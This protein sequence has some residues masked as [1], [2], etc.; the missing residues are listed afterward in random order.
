[1]DKWAALAHPLPTLGALAPTSPPLLQQRFMEKATSPAPAGSRVTPSSQEIRL[2]N[3]PTNS[4]GDPTR[5]C[6]KQQPVIVDVGPCCS[7]FIRALAQPLTFDVRNEGTL[8]RNLP[9]V[10][11]ARRCA[12]G[13]LLV[14]TRVAPSRLGGPDGRSAGR[15]GIVHRSTISRHVSWNCPCAVSHPW[16]TGWP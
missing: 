9:N 7:P 3:T 2:R 5:E 10:G 6:E 16:S 15:V 1:M 13:L 11:D 14:C 12:T 8:E 4:R